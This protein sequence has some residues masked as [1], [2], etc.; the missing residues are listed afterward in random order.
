MAELHVVGQLVG[1]SG[2][3]DKRVFCKWGVA[4]GTTWEL[5][6]GLDEGQTH[7][8]G[9]LNDEMAVWSHPIDLHYVSR[10]LTGWP[11][12][13]FQVWEQDMHG[14][15]DICGYGFC[16]IPAAPGMFELHCPT[17][18]PMGNLGERMSAHF[19]GGGPRLKLEEVVFTAGDRFRL[20]TTAG[21]IVHLELCVVAK[22]F[23]RHNVHFGE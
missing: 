6:E 11:K 22:D 15:N 1:A 9:S 5:V 14:R 2:F 20:Q 7:V 8:N 16:H 12:L 4:M 17:W 10:G 13:W 3:G 19:V 18:L 23:E 21:G